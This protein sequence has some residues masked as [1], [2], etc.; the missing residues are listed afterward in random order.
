MGV[1]VEDTTMEGLRAVLQ[2][3]LTLMW[4]GGGYSVGTLEMFTTAMAS[5]LRDEGRGEIKDDVSLLRLLEGIRRKLGCAI[6]K[7]MPLEGKQVA[8]LMGLGA[9]ATDGQSWTGEWAAFQWMEL[10]AVAVL[11]WAAFLRCCEIRNLQLCDLTWLESCVTVL[12]RKTK[13]DQRGYT[14]S[15]RVDA[16]CDDSP[17]CVYRFIKGYVL[18]V[19]GSCSRCNGCTKHRLPG[20]ECPVCPWLFPTI[21]CRG[22]QKE[23]LAERTLRGRLKAAVRRLE[24]S[25]VATPGQAKQTSVSSLRRGSDTEA[26]ARGCR[27]ELR[28][29]HGRW[30]AVAAQ[31]RSATAEPHYSAVKAGEK[32]AIMTV[33]HEALNEST[34]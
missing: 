25:G 11:G 21:S 8:A 4:F 30:G 26:A 32:G 28:E 13:A 9:P 24:E 23:Q 17:R 22:V 1:S 29:A 5:R 2:R 6:R 27:A 20:E 18:T 12:V 15:T 31:R 34:Q 16:A 10:V 14:T 7:K 19:L 33:L 3:A